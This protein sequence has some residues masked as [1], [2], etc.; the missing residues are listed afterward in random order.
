MKDSQEIEA[1]LALKIGYMYYHRPLMY[2]GTADGVDLLLHTYH[3]IWSEIE[4]RHDEFRN[5][6]WRVLEEEECGSANF[7]TRYRMNHPEASDEEI[8]SYAVDQWRKVS[9]RL[10][11]PIPHQQLRLSFRTHARRRV[12]DSRAVFVQ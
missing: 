11:V 4:G 12:N 6:W 8:V 3:E 10:G 1:I 2:G 9:T 7:S 5:T